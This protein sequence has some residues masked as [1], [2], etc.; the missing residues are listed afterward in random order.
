VGRRGAIGRR[1][2]LRTDPNEFGHLCVCSLEGM[3]SQIDQT[4]YTHRQLDFRTSTV[5]LLD[6]APPDGAVID[7]W[8][9][10]ADGPLGVMGCR[11]PARARRVYA[12]GDAL[13]VDRAALA[14]MGLVDARR[15]P[16]LRRAFHWFGVEP[17]PVDVRG[18]AGPLPGGFRNPWSRRRWRALSIASYPVYEYLSDE[19]KVFVPAMDPRAFPSSEPVRPALATIRRMAQRGVRAGTGPVTDPEV[20]EG[21]PRAGWRST[22][23]ESPSRC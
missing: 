16:I 4:V 7:A 12:G 19:G 23:F 9:P 3:A 20:L 13:T 1:Q 6:A 18:R 11:H 10:I 2:A 5:M 21:V 8:G 14:D 22:A 17:E 15:V